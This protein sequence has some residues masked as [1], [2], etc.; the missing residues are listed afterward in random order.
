M[1]NAV[2]DISHHNGSHLDFVKAHRAGIVGVIHKAS[3]G[4][5]MSDPMYSRNRIKAIDA[6][7]LFGAYH[8]GVGG[9]PTQQADHFLEAAKPDKQTLL[10]LD[11]EPNMQGA[12]MSLSEA[13]TFVQRIHEKTGRWPGLYSGNLIKETYP[14]GVHAVLK[15]CFLWLA[16][17]SQSPSNIPQTWP[18]WTLWQYTDGAHGPGDHSVDGIGYCDRDQFNGSLDGLRRLWNVAT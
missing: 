8:F 16:Q 12:T 9:N 15:N 2:I 11:Y 4:M 6:G 7:L 14:H 5:A 18:T 3:Q 1:L 10:V 17:Y 13:A